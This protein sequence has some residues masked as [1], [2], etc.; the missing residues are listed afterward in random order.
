MS[1]GC[2]AMAG[3]TSQ[4]SFSRAGAVS[5]VNAEHRDEA[6]VWCPEAGRRQNAQL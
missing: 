3:L 2:V 6:V 1:W 4:V 5:E